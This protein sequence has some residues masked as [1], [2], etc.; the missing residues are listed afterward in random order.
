MKVKIFF[1]LPI[2][3]ILT[4]VEL[5]AQ[6]DPL[7]G[8]YLNNPIVINP[9]YSGLNNRLTAAI[10]YRNQWAAFDGHPTTMAA[11][12]HL[13][14]YNNKLGAGVVLVS[15]KIGDMS[16]T[17]FSGSFAYKITNVDK[18]FSFAMQAGA[19]NYRIDPQGVNLQSPDDPTFSVIN[20]MKFNLGVG[21][22]FKTYRY[23]I[24]LSMPRMM[25]NSLQIQN[26]GLQ[27]YQRHFYLMGGYVHFL[28][29]RILLKP[30]VLIKGV[31]GA[32][33][34]IDLNFNVEIDRNYTVGAFTRNFKSFG[35]QAQMNVF[36]KFR[37]AYLFEL[38][39]RGSVGTQFTTHEIMIGIRTA[40][41]SFHDSKITNF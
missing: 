23:I 5:V 13:S 1:L 19:M 28:N 8:L 37:F 29:D 17:S 22:L 27:V 34:S 30:S 16:N 26:G 21:A 36:D 32:P 33:T 38:P 6:Q 4:W 40:V 18:V 7:Y 41:L 14:L 25:S 15:D 2:L 10:N 39:A 11:T 3:S 9:A 12:G 20:E 31:K 24:G 35:I